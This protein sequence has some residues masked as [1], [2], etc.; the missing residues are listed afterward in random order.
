MTNFGALAVLALPGIPERQLRVLLALET[1]TARDGG[2]RTIET[3]VLAAQARV[4]VNTAARARAELAKAGLI[5]YRPGTGPGHPGGYRLLVDVDKP[6]KNAGAVNPPKNAGAVNPPKPAPA[7]HP[8][9]PR[10][11]TTP[12]AVTSADASIALEPLALE[13][14]ALREAPDPARDPRTLLD[15]LGINERLREHITGWMDDHGVRDPFAYLLEITGKPENHEHGI[16]RFLDRRRRELNAC[17]PDG[18]GRHSGACRSGD[19]ARCAS[20]WCECACHPKPSAAGLDGH[21]T[22]TRIDLN[23]R[24]EARPA[25]QGRA[26]RLAHAWDDQPGPGYGQCPDCGLW[27]L[28]SLG[29]GRLKPHHGPVHGRECPGSRKRPA[30]PV[31]CTVCGNSR[32]V[33][34]SDGRCT[35]CIRNRWRTP[36]DLPPWHPASTP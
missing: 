4:S 9:E 5:E 22:E 31:P 14:S 1:V 15:G 24:A 25:S 3:G 10:K 13:P 34:R 26:A 19:S 28:V 32:V 30:E 27:V 35:T 23:G 6:P 21:L 11:P 16:R 2:W 20:S 18:P 12:N 29:G 33:L 7:S 17:D 8:N 36:A